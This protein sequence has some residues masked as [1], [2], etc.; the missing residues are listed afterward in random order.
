[1]NETTETVIENELKK[2]QV[3]I[4][5]IDKDNNEIKLEGVKFEVLDENGNVLETVTTDE[6]GEAYTSK[7]AIRDYSKLTIRESETL[8]NYVLDETPQTITLESNQ[9]KTITFENEKIKGYIE[10]TKI[11]EDDNK[12]NN[13]PARTNLE[14]AIFDIY[15]SQNNIVDTITTGKDGKAITKSL[16]KGNYIAKEKSSGSIYYLLNENEYNVEIKEHNEIIPLTITNKSVEISVNVEKTGYIETQK[17]DTIKYDFSNIANTSNIYLDS[18]KWTDYL[19]TDYIRLTEIVTGT[20]NQDII[21]SITYK[22]NLND[23]ERVLA[24]NL[25]SKENYKI[26]CK[27]IELQDNEYIT[28]YSFN[29]G[30]VDVGFKEEIAPSIFCM[31]LDTV[32]NKDTFTNKTETIGEYE[33]LT[34]KAKDEWTTV[35]YE[36]DI[37]A[38]K[39]P[40]TGN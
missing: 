29:F 28:E 10:I 20:W 23:K 18:F 9:I 2:G 11:S 21:Y 36:K 7:Y 24:E 8:E 33:N 4:I 14:G 17:N 13:L 30:K 22:T 19:P 26:D 40:K 15:D 39:L 34:D 6:S 37:H 25:N 38:K 32:K 12:Y 1:M 16:A 35:V 5:K 27:N 3:K 31:V